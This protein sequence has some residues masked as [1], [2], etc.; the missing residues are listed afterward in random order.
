[1]K[2]FLF[3]FG[4]RVGVFAAD[5]LHRFVGAREFLYTLF[6]MLLS[7]CYENYV[8]VNYN[9]FELHTDRRKKTTQIYLT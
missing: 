3:S 9:Y 8:I 7:N 6:N 4:M 2:P 1:M 5:D